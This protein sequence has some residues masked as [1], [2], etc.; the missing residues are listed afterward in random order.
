V[1][2]VGPY[3][4]E[5]EGISKVFETNRT[6]ALDRA[7]FRVSK[8]AIHA[9]VGENGAGKSTLMKILCGLERKNAGEILVDGIPKEIRSVKEAYANGIGMVNQ[10]F[11]LI[12][13]YTVLENILLGVE[14]TN[15]WGLI[16]RRESAKEV[17]KLIEMSR[18][19][20]PAGRKVSELTMGQRQLVEILR[21]LNRA[22]E[23]LILDEPTSVLSPREIDWLFSIIRELRARGKT[24]IF[25]SHR[26]DEVFELCDSIT[27]L[28]NGRDIAEGTLSDF[29]KKQV[30]FLMIGEPLGALNP[31][32]SPKQCPVLL[33]AE[34][35]SVRDADRKTEVVRSVNMM[36][37]GHEIAALVGVSNNGKQELVEALSGLRETS[38]GNIYLKDK[39]MTGS[40]PRGF[41]KA[42]IAFIPEDRVRMG[43]SV[44]S[45][46]LDNILATKYFEAPYTKRGWIN[47]KEAGK[48]AESLIREYRIKGASV[49]APLA[50]LSG[51]NIQRVIL[52]REISSDPSV[53]ILCEP[54]WG[55][56]HRSCDHIYER[57]YELAESGKAVLIVSSYLDEALR[58]ANRI[59]VIYKGEIIAELENSSSLTKIAIG[60]LMLGLGR[61]LS[62][63]YEGDGSS[64]KA[65]SF[66]GHT[67]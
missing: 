44:S 58:L 4:I 59:F 7:R 25:I 51:G 64:I 67:S 32:R 8:G 36:L 62:Q 41:R 42:G 29:D 9:L 31:K 16:D 35:L 21:I 43:A 20:L 11:H 6:V 24:I 17:Q 1:K 19:E 23:I 63:G 5:M 22:V 13:D 47:R 18:L 10:Q 49:H 14:K 33:R 34:N 66:D 38:S 50:T 40:T 37:R 28:R 12:E 39:K 45:S 65:G 2:T 52:A 46:V 30:S 15:R 57:L 48:T 60:E 56:D 3:A 53:L 26:L 55:L 54:T 61:P 27:I